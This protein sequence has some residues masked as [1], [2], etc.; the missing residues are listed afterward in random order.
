MYTFD[1]TTVGAWNGTSTNSPN[2]TYTFSFYETSNDVL[3][4]KIFQYLWYRLL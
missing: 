1:F 2:G 4:T 3:V